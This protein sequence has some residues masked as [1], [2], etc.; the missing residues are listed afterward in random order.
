[1]VFCKLFS[2]LVD[3]LFDYCI[4]FNFLDCITLSTNNPNITCP[5]CLKND[6]CFYC[7]TDN[8]CKKLEFD[9]IFPRGCKASEARWF[10]C[11]C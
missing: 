11:G 8:Q 6:K 2:N 4:K 5:A 1:M 10:S 9:G 3:K 7:Y